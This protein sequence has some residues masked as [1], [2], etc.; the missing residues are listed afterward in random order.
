MGFRRRG[1]RR[2]RVRVARLSRKKDDG[3]WPLDLAPAVEI[4]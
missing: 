4:I 3:P 1:R 2:G